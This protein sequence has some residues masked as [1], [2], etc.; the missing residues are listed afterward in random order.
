MCLASSSSQINELGGNLKIK[1]IA[2]L[3]CAPLAANAQKLLV[4]YQGTVSSVHG[5]E[6]AEPFPYSVGDS[7]S[8]TLIID[9]SLAPPDKL[10]GDSQIGRYSTPGIDFILG[11]T[12]PA[13][14]GSG[15]LLLVYDDWE[16]PSSGTA[17]QDG[18]LI[19]DQ[20]IG[21]DGEFN[22]VLGMQRPNVLGQIFQNDALAQSFAVEPEPEM[23]LWGYIER[24]F[25]ELWR[26]VHFT[27]DRFSVTP[28]VCRP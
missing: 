1:I 13:G 15:D 9:T 2:A 5:A 7:I 3:F 22:L 26:A 6:L 17:A 20:S 4:E 25:G 19:R 8:G 24:G 11:P 16:S 12:R 23:D 28:G 21:T 18:I 10:P 27:L 14:P